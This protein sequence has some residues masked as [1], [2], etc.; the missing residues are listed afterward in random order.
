MTDEKF[1]NMTVDRIC[2]LAGQNGGNIT[3]AIQQHSADTGIPAE[4]IEQLYREKMK[5]N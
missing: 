4:H 5:L 2:I 3:Q 1:E